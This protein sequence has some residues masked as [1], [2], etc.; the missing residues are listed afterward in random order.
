MWE[1]FVEPSRFQLHML[2]KCGDC[3]LDLSPSTDVCLSSSKQLNLNISEPLIEVCECE[4]FFLAM[5]CSRKENFSCHIAN[6]VLPL[7][8]IV[9]RFG[10]SRNAAFAMNLDVRYV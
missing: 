10:F 4:F 6:G 7:F 3:G 8:Q 2:R 5:R 9:S 1:P